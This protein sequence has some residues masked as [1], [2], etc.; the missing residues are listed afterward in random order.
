MKT[1]SWLSGAS[2]IGG[3]WV[4]LSPVIVGFSASNP[5]HPWT[6]SMDIATVFG[7]LLI[8]AGLVGMVGFYAAMAAKAPQPVP[9][10]G[11]G[12]ET[13]Q[14]QRPRR[15]EVRRP[16]HS[17]QSPASAPASPKADDTDALL[18][19]LMHRLLNDTHA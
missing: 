3:L 18:N 6:A 8:I 10:T 16:T 1:A 13:L 12:P 15:E 5:H 9:V 14:P 19:E 17:P 2:I 4:M 11:A 7:G